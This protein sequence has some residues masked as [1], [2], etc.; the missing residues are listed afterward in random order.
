VK[1]GD[2]EC[3]GLLTRGEPVALG[4]GQHEACR[5]RRRSFGRG[6]GAAER[7]R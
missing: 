7:G 1:H 2:V 4:P 3:L 5:M 6:E